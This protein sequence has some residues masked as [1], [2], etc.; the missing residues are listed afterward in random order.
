MKPQIEIVEQGP[1]ECCPKCQSEGLRNHG[2]TCL[3]GFGVYLLPKYSCADC[4]HEWAWKPLSTVELCAK[5]A[6]ENESQPPP[7]Q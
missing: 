1:T 7:E 6:K 5:I 4:G 3:V 2:L